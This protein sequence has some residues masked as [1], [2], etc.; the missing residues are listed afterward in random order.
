MSSS[1]AVGIRPALVYVDYTR[2]RIGRIEQ[3]LTKESLGCRRI[4]L[5]REP[6]SNGLPCGIHSVQISVLPFD[7]DLGLIDAIAFINPFQ[8]RAAAPVQFRPVDLDP[9]PDAAGVDEQT[10]FE[11]HLRHMRK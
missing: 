3:G 9:A 6:E 1:T 4:A 7:P 11:R 5:G 10:T 8:V 2:L